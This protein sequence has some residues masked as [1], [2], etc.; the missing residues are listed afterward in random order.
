MG[1]HV[2]RKVTTVE[3]PSSSASGRFLRNDGSSNNRLPLLSDIDSDSETEIYHTT[4]QG[5]SSSRDQSNPEDI[6]MKD[7]RQW[8]SVRDSHIENIYKDN[9]SSFKNS[10]GIISL[11]NENCAVTDDIVEVDIDESID[12][13][14][15]ILEAEKLLDQLDLLS[16]SE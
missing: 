8:T 11:S 14:D 10:H 13:N 1:L 9:V 6:F 7:H 16:S 2:I 4:R 12:S 3:R 5:T 15:A